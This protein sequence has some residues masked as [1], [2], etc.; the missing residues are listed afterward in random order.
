MWF[1]PEARFRVL[2]ARRASDGEIVATRLL[3][4]EKYDKAEALEEA[5]GRET[6]AL[7]GTLGSGHELFE[8]P[9][10]GPRPLLAEW[11]RGQAKLRFILV[12]RKTG[13]KDM[14]VRKFMDAAKYRNQAAFDKAVN[15]EKAKLGGTY[16]AGEW[17]VLEIGAE[18]LADFKARH[19]DLAK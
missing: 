4:S 8:S 3:D 19:P 6:V 15:D 10:P 2:L 12:R 18:S 16:P 7:A 13:K 1:S 17:D 9:C 5:V 14:P 11:W